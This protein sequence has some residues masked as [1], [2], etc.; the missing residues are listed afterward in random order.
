M[1]NENFNS[2]TASMF[3]NK[4]AYNKYIEKTAPKKHVEKQN[5]IHK[6]EKYKRKIHNIVHQ[7]LDDP[8][9][10][11]SLDVNSALYELGK[12]LIQYLEIKDI[13]K[14]GGCYETNARE[15]DSENTLLNPG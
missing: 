8:D 1:D 14:E 7:Y 9:T 3:M 13:D 10:N 11:F 5:Y 15:E 4:S 2:F 12:S 6:L